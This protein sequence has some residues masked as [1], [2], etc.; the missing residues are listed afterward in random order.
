MPEQSLYIRSHFASEAQFRS[1]AQKFVLEEMCSRRVKF[2]TWRK[3]MIRFNFHFCSV[4]VCAICFFFWKINQYV[5]TNR[6][7][8][9]R[10]YYAVR[11]FWGSGSR[12]IKWDLFY[13]QPIQF[14]SNFLFFLGLFFFVANFHGKT[15]FT[16]LL[17]FFCVW[18]VCSI[19]GGNIAFHGYAT[20]LG[21]FWVSWKSW[22]IP[23]CPSYCSKAWGFTW[24]SVKCESIA[25]KG[26]CKKFFLRL[27][28]K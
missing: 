10:H 20:I 1:V 9:L 13:L 6:E 22:S 19:L 28:P 26:R 24:E 21:V 16:H 25:S 8:Y 14:S 17:F 23:H 12:K 18:T 27:S 5:E 2:F 15:L 4:S 7:F 3:A 11:A